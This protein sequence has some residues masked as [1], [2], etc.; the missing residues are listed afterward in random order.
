MRRAVVEVGRAGLRRATRAS[1]GPRSGSS[2]G[3]GLPDARSRARAGSGGGAGHRHRRR[4]A[5]ARAAPALGH[6]D[7]AALER[8]VGGGD[9]RRAERELARER[10][11]RREPLRRAQRALADRGLEALGEAG[12]AP[13]AQILL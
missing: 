7:A 5:H 3:S 11:H 6:E 10:A 4:E 9:G 8:A 12:G 1:A 2:A 13:A